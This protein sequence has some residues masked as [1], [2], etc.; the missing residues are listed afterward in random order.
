LIRHDQQTDSARKRII[1]E[2]SPAGK[3]K[4]REE[5]APR[6]A[7]E[8]GL[9][10]SAAHGQVS[11]SCMGIPL[12][13]ETASL[14]MANSLIL[15]VMALVVFGPRRLPEMGRKLGKLMYE[16]RKASNDFKFQMEEELRN[17]EE[18][19][20]RKREE[21]ER[22]Q[23]LTLAPPEPA[24]TA[25]P[26]SAANVHVL[27]AGTDTPGEVAT[28][29]TESPYPYEGAY[30]KLN[31]QETAAEETSAQI[32]PEEPVAAAPETAENAAPITDL[33]TPE[34]DVKQASETDA[35][36]NTAVAQ[37][38]AEKETTVAEANAPA[39]S[40]VHNG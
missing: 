15:M 13:I 28:T 19:D 6:P 27:E 11:L 33:A 22:L 34:T 1:A 38:P 3:Q 21:A 8:P 17:A 7:R 24:P 18:A 30:P 20:R 16:F 23:T 29:T 26:E 10:V 4:N 25:E 35:A 5:R 12:T 39:E 9:F 2:K 36:V 37:I 14:G 32:H 31:D 40:A